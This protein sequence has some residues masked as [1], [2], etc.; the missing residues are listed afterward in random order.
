MV[1]DQVKFMVADDDE[2]EYPDP[3]GCFKDTAFDRVLTDKFSSGEM[4]PTVGKSP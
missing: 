4:T 3:V 2:T 1:F